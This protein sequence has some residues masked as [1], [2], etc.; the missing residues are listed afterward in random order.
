MK[1]I[2]LL[3]V[4]GILGMLF[5]AGTDRKAENKYNFITGSPEV[6]SITALAFGPSGIL[7]IGDAQNSTVIAFDTKDA[8]KAT[9]SLNYDVKNI[10]AKIAEALGTVKENISIIDMVVNPVSK[11]LY[12]AVKSADGS[13][14]LLTMSAKNEIQAVS[15]KNINFSSVLLNNYPSDDKKDRQGKPLRNLS[16]SDMGYDNGKLMISGLSN[17]EFSSSFRSIS[18]PFTGKQDEESTLE[19]YHAQHGRYETTSPIRTFTTTAINGKN[20]IVASY[21]CT[22]LVLF[23]LDE[24]KPGAHVMGRT[25]AEMGNRNTPSDMIWLK[26]GSQTFL[27]MAND[28]RPAVKV[29]YDDITKFQGTLTEKIS[30]TGGTNFTKLPYEKIMQ[31]AKL[32]ENKAVMIQKKSNGDIDLWTSSGKNI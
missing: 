5:L 15:L 27:V 18:F 2:P 31:L 3:I 1:K 12:L 14:V 16:I 13:P 32:D 10:D 29:S 30:E 22:P 20:Y 25:I 4:T 11:K 24:L 21:T 9:G 23:P 7:F 28:N 19:M 6:K 26:E 17:K 8:K